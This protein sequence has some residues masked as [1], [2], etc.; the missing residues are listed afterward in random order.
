M[1]ADEWKR[2]LREALTRALRARDAVTVSAVRQ[3]LAAIDNAEAVALTAAPKPQEGPIAGGVAG[4]GAGEVARRV[5]GADE[6]AAIFARE[7][8][9][10]SAAAETLATVGRDAEA[11]VLRKQRE[12]L[13]SLSPWGEG[14]PPLD[15][16]D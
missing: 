14:K 7:Q 2:V 9:E 1:T 16:V 6:L 13:A 5:L 3:T 15:E 10:R 8:Q 12:L 11:A 4:L